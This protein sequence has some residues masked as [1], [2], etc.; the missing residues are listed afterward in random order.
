MIGKTERYKVL[1]MVKD[2][3]VSPEEGEQMLAVLDKAVNIV[4]CP[5]CAKENDS[6]VAQCV[7]CNAKLPPVEPPKWAKQIEKPGFGQMIK[8]FIK[9][10][11]STNKQ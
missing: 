11:F 10:L 3:K 6:T 2:G 9:K 1:Q 8:S 7:Y 4:R 5:Y